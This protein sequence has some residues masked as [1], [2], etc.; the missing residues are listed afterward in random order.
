MNPPKYARIIRL[1]TSRALLHRCN[2]MPPFSRVALPSG[3]ALLRKYA[4]TRKHI[5]SVRC[6]VLLH[7]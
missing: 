6:W 1:L 4:L 3:A 2:G 5:Y 7:F